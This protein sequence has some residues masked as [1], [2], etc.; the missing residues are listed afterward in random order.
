MFGTSRRLIASAICNTT[1]ILDDFSHPMNV[2]AMIETMDSTFIVVVGEEDEE[3]EERVEIPETISRNYGRNLNEESNKT[4]RVSTTDALTAWTSAYLQLDTCTPVTQQEDSIESI[5]QMIQDLFHSDNAKVN[6]ALDA[7]K[8]DLNKDK[9]KCSK[10]QGVGGCL[11]LVLLLKKC[12]DNSIDIIPACDQVTEL[13]ELAE[14]ATLRKTLGVIINLT[15]NHHESRVGISRIGGVEAVVK[16]MKTFP[17]CQ[18]LQV[19][20]SKSLLNLTYNNA[21]GKV[22]IIESGGI[23]VLLAA[24]NNHLGCASVC[25]KACSTLFSAANASKEKNGLLI[26]LGVGVIVD[27][28]RTKWPDNKAVQTQVRKL[29]NLIAME[30]KARADE[31]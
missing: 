22:T 4:R 7:L 9:E 31:E 27:K 29:A 21:T 5:G 23:E 10:I 15:F 14:L 12:L 2:A 20:A 17:K 3:E 25:L 6:T 13:N 26:R 30:W 8:V 16:V 24:I 18:V 11:A 28:V 1:S 19:N